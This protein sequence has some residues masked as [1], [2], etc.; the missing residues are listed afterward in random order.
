MIVGWTA[1]ESA[2]HPG[3]VD[4]VALDA[5]FRSLKSNRVT[6][7]GADGAT[8]VGRF[9]PGRSGATIILSHGY[10]SDKE[11]MLPW[12]NFL[13]QAGFS[14]FS[15]DM[16]GCGES[17]GTITFGALEPRDL[18]SAVDYLDSRSD[19]DRSRIGALGYSLGGPVTVMAAAADSR[20]KAV[21][22]DSGYA[23]IRHWFKDGLRAFVSHPTEPFSTL[24]LRF[25]EWRLGINADNLRPVT[26]I[27]LISP[28]PVLFIQGTADSVVPVS[29]STAYFEAARQPKELWQVRGAGHGQAF[30]MASIAYQKRVISFF[31]KAL[32]P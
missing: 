11:Q 32:L 13:H 16:R 15:Y 30:Q 24:S 14:I 27:A 28:R 5:R 20:I 25:I 6:F 18:L 9:F 19:V 10:G 29:D 23:D 8:L 26:K 12:V 17:G 21:I 22:E 7:S 1:S 31:R 4:D 3:K 2:I